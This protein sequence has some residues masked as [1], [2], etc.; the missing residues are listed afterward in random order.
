VRRRLNALCH[1]GFYDAFRTLHPKDPGYTF[2][3]Y[4]GNALAADFGMRIDYLFLNAPAVDRLLS[5]TVD[6]SPRLAPK[7]SDHTALVAEFRP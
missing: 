6:K 1:G 4:T 5:C 3:D 2:W 7:P